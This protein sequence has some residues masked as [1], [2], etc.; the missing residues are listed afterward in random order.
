M[1]GCYN[2]LIYGF[3]TY[4]LFQVQAVDLTCPIINI[5]DHTVKQPI[6]IEHFMPLANK[7]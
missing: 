6:K 2:A 7:L 4:W 5:C 3:N 1:I